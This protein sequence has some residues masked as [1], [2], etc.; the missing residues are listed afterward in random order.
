[1]QVP[2]AAFRTVSQEA[3]FVDLWTNGKRVRVPAPFLPYAYRKERLAGGYAKEERVTVR[4][5]STLA[6]ETWYRYHF[7]NVRGV[8][9]Q[10]RGAPALATA[11]DHVAYIERILIDAPTWYRQ[12]A[13]T[14]PLKLLVIDIEQL[15]DGQGFPTA[16][17]PLIS[18]GWA[19]S[20]EG[21][22]PGE[23]EC[24]L[25]DGKTDRDILLAFA[26]KVRA[27]DPDVIVGYNVTGYDLPMIVARMRENGLDTGLLSRSGAASYEDDENEVRIDGR[28]VY[29]V[30]ESV[31]LDQTLFGIKDRRLKT[32][33]AWLGYPVVKEDTSD[34]RSLV[35]TDRLAAYNKSDVALTRSIANIYWKNFVA[36]AEFYGAPLN[37]VLRA[38]PAFHVTVLQGRVFRQADPPIVSDGK[39]SERYRGL[40]FGPSATEDGDEAGDAGGLREAFVGG[41]VEIYQRGLFT[42]VY[43]C[44]FSSMYPSIMVS[45]GTG[46]DNTRIIGSE[47]LAPF[48]VK[49]DGER[50]IYSIPDDGRRINHLVE[51]TGVSP[52]A[53]ELAS[54]LALRLDLKKRAKATADPVEKER[55]NAQQNVIKVVLNSIYGVMAS[56]FARYGS[57]PVA[58]AIVGVARRLIRMV[59]DELGDAKIETDTDGVYTAAKPDIERLNAVV[60]DFVS[61]ELG[62]ENYTR[63]E[64]ES[65]EAGYFHQR[66]SY[67][68]LHKDGRVE[69]HGI[70]F[71]GSSLCGVF[72]KTLDRVSKALLTGGDARAVGR[73]AFDMAKYDPAD[74]VMRVRLGKDLADYAAANAVGAQV[75]RKVH[76]RTGRMPKKGEQLE[77]VKTSRGYDVVSP[78]SLAD[79]DLDYYKGL[80]ET[81]LER[82]DIDWRPTR[83][84]SLMEF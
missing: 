3:Q 32:V 84:R 31:K 26:K 6:P 80:V 60:A 7:Q 19:E 52:M 10:S 72:D 30:F 50:R 5:L 48:T 74:F 45:L 14:A 62:G 34:T 81:V 57:L 75:A 54:L 53:K 46:A 13:N 44:D 41:I 8:S 22:P 39:N 47:P 71:K 2:L 63:I 4:P 55:L 82:L 58:I 18:I 37:V 38:T 17:S 27:Y 24:V 23:P 70:A 36:L 43:K 67:L 68:L 79:L 12:F 25:G 9:D 76:E 16:K 59:E 21:A 28:L 66:K 49:S 40:Y 20:T 51:I 15:T 33:A 83:Q 11:D 1:V 78:E 73:E 29:D 35:G 65:F 42:P 61:R 77:Y 69:K 56:S 64:A